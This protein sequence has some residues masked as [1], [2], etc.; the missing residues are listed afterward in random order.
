MASGAPDSHE[1]LLERTLARFGALGPLVT[2]PARAE[3][4]HV[5]GTWKAA[6]ARLWGALYAA[7]GL[8]SLR[9]AL[10]TAGELSILNVLAIPAPGSAAPLFGA[11][12][13]RLPG[14]D[15]MAAVD[16]S[17]GL[18]PSAGAPPWLDR[19]AAVA[20]R[21]CDLPSG[22]VLPEWATRVFSPHPLYTRYPPE[23]EARAQQAFMA[24][25][26]LFLLLVAAIPAQPA[27]CQPQRQA[28]RAYAE[29]HRLED[30]GLLMLGRMFGEAWAAR[31]LTDF[32]FPDPGPDQV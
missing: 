20:G 18:P 28:L 6:P 17:P 22:G 27:L 10:I 23:Q 12:L 29:A 4:L 25:L 9:L 15:R 16:L 1:S 7:P 19:Q 32:L 14:R 30:R 2:V 11:D 8:A 3:Y 13:V 24:Y 21:Y 5:T 26:E 31:Y